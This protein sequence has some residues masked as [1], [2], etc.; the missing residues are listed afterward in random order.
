M[1]THILINWFCFYFGVKIATRQCRA[2]CITN[3]NLCDF[4]QFAFFPSCIQFRRKFAKMHL[5]NWQLYLP[6]TIGY[7]QPCSP[8]LNHIP[9]VMHM[10]YIFFLQFNIGHFYPHPTGSLH[11][12]R[13]RICQIGVKFL[14]NS[15]K[16]VFKNVKVR[17][18]TG[19]DMSSPELII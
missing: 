14:L 9:I 10:A 2:G 12:T 8:Q 19:L 13:A 18:N 16:F 1:T 15:G 7:V 11:C 3:F 5:S 17:Q 6:S 4:Q